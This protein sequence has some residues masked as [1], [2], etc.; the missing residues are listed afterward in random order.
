MAISCYVMKGSENQFSLN[1]WDVE[2]HESMIVA[3]PAHMSVKWWD[4]VLGDY[5]QSE[6]SFDPKSTAAVWPQFLKNSAGIL[7]KLQD[8]ARVHCEKYG[9]KKANAQVH[10]SKSSTK[11]QLIKRPASHGNR[12]KTKPKGAAKP[13]AVAKPKTADNAMKHNH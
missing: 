9:K 5:R 13:K 8:D 4:K 11:V 2:N 7:Q 10:P 3:T 1:W 12:S 6:C